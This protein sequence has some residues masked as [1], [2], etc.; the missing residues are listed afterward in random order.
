[1]IG[2]TVSHYKILEKLGEGGM[3]VVYKALDKDLNRLVAIKFLGPSLQQSFQGKERFVREA[4]AASSVNHPN[5]CTIHEIG[6]LGG[7]IFIVMEFVEGVPLSRIIGGGS[8][9]GVGRNSTD[10]AWM[11]GIAIQIAEGLQK[12]HEKSLIHRDIKPDNIMVTPDGLVKVMDFGLAKVAGEESLTADLSTVGTV[13]YMSPE[14]AQGLPLDHR[15][16]IFSFGSVLYEM[17]SGKAP[18]KGEHLAATIYEVVNVDPSPLTEMCAGAD[19]ELNR[20]VLKCLAKIPDQRYQSMSDVLANLRAYLPQAAGKVIRHDSTKPEKHFR[21]TGSISGNGHV[22]GERS[23]SKGHR[24]VL[25]GG[26]GIVLALA[27]VLVLLWAPWS[28]ANTAVVTL[29]S[30]PG[31][32][33]IVL[34]GKMIG[35]TPIVDFRTKAGIVSV[36]A[37]CEGFQPFD[38]TLFLIGGEA[39]ELIVRPLP[40]QESGLG[41]ALPYAISQR[42]DE[43]RDSS[44]PA[45]TSV[46]KTAKVS[47]TFK[48]VE[49]LAEHF[50][51]SLGKENELVTGKIL[52]LPFTY[53]GTKIAST[54]SLILRN[55]LDHHL[56][57]A[58]SWNIIGP[59]GVSFAGGGDLGG[60]GQPWGV[61]SGFYWTTGDILTCVAELRKVVGGELVCKANGG[62]AISE[63][64]S[65]G[66]AVKPGNFSQAIQYQAAVEPKSTL[67]SDLKLSLWTNKGKA[68]LLFQEHETLQVYV[69]VNMTCNVRLIYV[70]ANN[71]KVLLT[72]DLELAGDDVNRDTMAKK[73]V[74][75]PPF[76][77]EMIQAFASTGT[78]ASVRVTRRND[79]LLV[80]AEDIRE[81][82]EK[83]RGIYE[84]I[85]GIQRAEAVVVL[86]T[87]ESGGR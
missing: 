53:R 61:L 18:F 54:F 81:A 13:A 23:H 20:I 1:V 38:T 32:I 15:T 2:S 75:G 47:E 10:V 31:G 80:V 29:Y 28:V 74:C 77:A 62:L 72:P 56:A 67:Q 55:R 84:P 70:Q 79:G 52:L 21:T 9:A 19:A 14:Q 82:V 66:V 51:F 85:P 45:P 7:D 35:T 44:N 39:S 36:H 30:E 65:Q 22:K 73:V 48:T 6:E 26:V 41:S 68:N 49:D 78:L 71:E 43:V 40:L 25:L 83:T 4:Q 76:G 37:V 59:E 86:T 58:V 16:D 17:M 87:V 63:L 27:V 60:N 57:N 33:Q 46:R 8:H 64:A 12:A 42:R 3:G 11:L 34:N 24:L 69:R 50:S 5:I